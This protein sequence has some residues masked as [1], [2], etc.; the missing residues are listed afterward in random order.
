MTHYIKNYFSVVYVKVLSVSA[1]P[2]SAGRLELRLSE[3]E[4]RHRTIVKTAAE[5]I[6]ITDVETRQ[7]SFPYLTAIHYGVF[8]PTRPRDS[9]ASP[10]CA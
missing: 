10:A 2:Q 7:F 4:T 1:R 9:R 3:A 6:L 5:A 8:F